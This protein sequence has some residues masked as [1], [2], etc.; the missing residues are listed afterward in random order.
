MALRWE[1]N[2]VGAQVLVQSICLNAVSCIFVGTRIWLR[3]SKLRK[4]YL[5]DYIL[6][7]ALL[8]SIALTVD[9]EFQRRSGSGLHRW[10]LQSM[11]LHPG[12]FLFWLWMSILLYQTTIFLT[13][14]ALAFQYY[15]V[16]K[17]R[18]QRIQSLILGLFVTLTYV[19]VL[20][21]TI[22]FV[23]RPTK[24]F[25]NPELAGTCL[26]L[27]VLGPVNGA[28]SVIGNL[29][30]IVLPIPAIGKL[31]LPKRT[32]WAL[33]V[34]FLFGLAECVVSFARL[35]TLIKVLSAN[36]MLY[37]TRY[38]SLWT[39]AEANVGLMCICIPAFQPLLSRWLPRAFGGTNQDS[40]R[41][42]QQM[43][44]GSRSGYERAESGSTAHTNP[45]R[46]RSPEV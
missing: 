5:E 4:L 46:A 29:L 15:R 16:F 10:Q 45:N 37:Y 7:L 36:D 32:K 43:S 25:W 44:R 6:T 12:E 11:H 41:Q 17:F 3:I 19:Q 38:A 13:K 28:L 33:S 27:H 40:T 2:P 22:V 20:L 23:C 24:K 14:L 30:L 18:V 1:Q 31:N 34:A 39:V 42:T 9:I 35:Y 21:T 26:P 8:V